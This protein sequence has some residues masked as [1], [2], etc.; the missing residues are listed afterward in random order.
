[1]RDILSWVAETFGGSKAKTN[2]AAPK[3]PTLKALPPGF[4]PQ[5]LG[6]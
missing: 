4:K 2:D 6:R 1:M 3:K 5:Q